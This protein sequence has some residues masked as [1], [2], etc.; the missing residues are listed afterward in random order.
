M[1]PN[2]E[3]W[4]FNHP[5]RKTHLSPNVNSSR[6]MMPHTACSIPPTKMI[7]RRGFDLLSERLRVITPEPREIKHPRSLL[8]GRRRI[9]E[10]TI[11]S[12][13]TVMVVY[14]PSVTLLAQPELLEQL[15][16]FSLYYARAWDPSFP[17]YR[18][19]SGH[20]GW[21]DEQQQWPC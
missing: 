20:H 11:L 12:K 9:P 5:S 17:S 3:W 2:T 16:N 13:W 8:A 21:T 1:L 6:K 10:G 14:L 4:L 18:V 7:V 15:A 19:H